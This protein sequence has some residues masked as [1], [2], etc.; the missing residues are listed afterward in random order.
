M[1]KCKHTSTLVFESAPG[2][3]CQVCWHCDELVGWGPSNDSD[4]AVAIEIR[5]AE[6]AGDTTASMFAGW[7]QH[8]FGTSPGPGREVPWLARQIWSHDENKE[9]P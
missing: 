7:E 2:V 1:T 3:D 8:Y 9:E 6:L 5:A 4:P